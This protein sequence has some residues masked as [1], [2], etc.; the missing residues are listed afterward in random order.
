MEITQTS[1]ILFVGTTMFLLLTAGMIFFFVKAFTFAKE[2]DIAYY[3]LMKNEGHVGRAAYVQIADITIKLQGSHPGKY[4]PKFS[5]ICNT[6]K[7]S[8]EKGFARIDESKKV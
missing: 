5:E 6:A 1:F 8:L 4:S 7:K 3:I 2:R